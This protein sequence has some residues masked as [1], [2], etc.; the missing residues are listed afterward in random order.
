MFAG[1]SPWH[2]WLQHS[3]VFR[4]RPFLHCQ[5][6]ISFVQP[7]FCFV[8]IALFA[9]LFLLS[10]IMPLEKVVLQASEVLPAQC[11]S[12]PLHSME[13][14]VTKAQ[15]TSL[16][17]VSM[18]ACV[19]CYDGQQMKCSDG[20]QQQIYSNIFKYFQTFSNIFKYFQKN[21]NIFKY[22]KIYSDIFKYIQMGASSKRRSTSK[23]GGQA[24]RDRR[25]QKH[26]GES[27]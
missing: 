11:L 1:H 12:L 17:L 26:P 10:T 14:Q 18:N 6:C 13:I 27:S 25:H 7:H 19:P 8:N 21:S 20:G 23:E 24:C 16:Q 22:I 15:F 3:P 9:Q 4:I 5:V 2:F